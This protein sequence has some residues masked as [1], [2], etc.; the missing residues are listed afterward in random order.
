VRLALLS[1][2]GILCVSAAL[3]VGG[4][5]ANR[6]PLTRPPGIRERL[7]TYLTTHV[8]ETARDARFPELRTRPYTVPPGDL[9]EAVSMASAALGW[10]LATADRERGAIEAIV[11]SRIWRFKDDVSIRVEPLAQHGSVLHARSA[12]RRGR[13]DLGANSRHIMDLLAAL[14]SRLPPH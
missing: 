9:Y 13:G 5:V 14:E 8:A 1:I 4:L 12:S 3:V 10:E 7:A 6:L 2:M 11:T